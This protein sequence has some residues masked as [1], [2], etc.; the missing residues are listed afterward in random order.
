MPKGYLVHNGWREVGAVEALQRVRHALAL[1]YKTMLGPVRFCRGSKVL[2][3]CRYS[4]VCVR[5]MRMAVDLRRGSVRSVAI[6]L[7]SKQQ[8]VSKA[9]V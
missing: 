4:A 3:C 5:S 9:Q 7:C 2:A 6:G 1:Y 8:N